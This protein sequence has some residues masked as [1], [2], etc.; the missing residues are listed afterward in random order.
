MRETWVILLNNDQ[1]ILLL[2]IP[3]TKEVMRITGRATI[4][5]NSVLLERMV[6][7]GKSEVLC[8]NVDVDECFF[9]CGR[10][11]NR[12]HLWLLEKWPKSEGNYWRDQLVQERKMNEK[13]IL[14]M[15]RGIKDLLDE[16]GESDGAYWFPPLYAGENWLPFILCLFDLPH[17]NFEGL[18]SKSFKFTNDSETKIQWVIP[19][20][21]V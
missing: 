13:E 6:S 16:L 15:E 21:P 14:E 9:H 8:I 18:D 3:W 11:F 7:C 1:V 5:S 17:N 12:S 2:I 4:T 20:N 10:A 19:M